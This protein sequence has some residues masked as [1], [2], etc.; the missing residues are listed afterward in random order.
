M[1]I[2][3]MESGE[4]WRTM[5]STVKNGGRNPGLYR[6]SCQ[7]ESNWQVRKIPEETV[8]EQAAILAVASDR[9]RIDNNR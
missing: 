7:A 9:Y 6:F 2:V 8:I 1:V 4:R 3:D 5:I